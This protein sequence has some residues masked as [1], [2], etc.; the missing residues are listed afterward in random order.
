MNV[1]V[2]LKYS[3][4]AWKF[5]K[6]FCVAKDKEKLEK[7]LD[8]NPWAKKSIEHLRNVEKGFNTK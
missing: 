1:E 3:F 5:M 7:A 4:W 2:I 6:Y 8:G